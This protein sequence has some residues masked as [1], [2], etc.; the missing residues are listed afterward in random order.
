VCAAKTA[1]NGGLSCFELLD[2]FT[3]LGPA[4]LWQTCGQRVDFLGQQGKA[5]MVLSC[6]ADDLGHPES[7][8]AGQEFLLDRGFDESGAG[9]DLLVIRIAIE[10]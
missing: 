1:V 2:D 5:L 8:P 3:T 9:A 6:R 10:R 7:A 4:C